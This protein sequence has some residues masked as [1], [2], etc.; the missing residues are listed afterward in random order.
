MVKIVAN[1]VRQTVFYEGLYAIRVAKRL[2]R[3]KVA[4]RANIDASYFA[5]LERGDRN[6]P[7]YETLAKILDSLEATSQEKE[8]LEQAAFFTRL[9][10]QI[11]GKHKAKYAEAVV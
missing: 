7:T 6:P 5:A 11:S 9:K 1:L 8:R 4:A 3:K 10:N 2:P